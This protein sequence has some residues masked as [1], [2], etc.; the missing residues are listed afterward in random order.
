MI[1]SEF[2]GSVLALIFAASK[3][4]EKLRVIA[5]KTPGIALPDQAAALNDIAVL[6]GGVAKVKA[7]EDLL[8]KVRMADLGHARKA[9]AGY[10]FFSILGGKGDARKLRDHISGLKGAL[11]I[12]ADHNTHKRIQERI[13]KL[14]G[15]AATLFVPGISPSEVTVKTEL[16]TRTV[17]TLQ[18]ALREGVVPGGGVALLNCRPALLKKMHTCTEAD[19]RAAYQILIKA[20]EAPTRALLK[21]PG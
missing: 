20:L 18:A 10:D 16:A 9:R 17:S 2:S 12:E 1:G 6:T 4:P 11:N 15:G 21:M 19:E 13:G 5:V 8:E 7:A 14:M 3:N